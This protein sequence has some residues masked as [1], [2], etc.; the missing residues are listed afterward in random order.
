MFY[1]LPLNQISGCSDQ[2]GG[3]LHS[4]LILPLKETRHNLS[5]V[6]DLKLKFGALKSLKNE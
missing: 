6:E 5:L 4:C 3:L 2:E 1:S